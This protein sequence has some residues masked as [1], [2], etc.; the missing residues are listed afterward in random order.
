LADLAEPALRAV[1]ALERAGTAGAVAVLRGLAAG[2]PE[3][4]LTQEAQ[5]S[6]A[7]LKG[8]QASGR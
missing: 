6:L 4:R 7:R 1:E 5:A 8:R 3:A 2:V